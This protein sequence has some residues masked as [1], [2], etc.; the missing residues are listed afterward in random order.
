MT[1]TDILAIYKPMGILVEVLDITID[2][3]GTKW[4]TVKDLEGKH[5]VGGNPYPIKTQYGVVNSQDLESVYICNCFL[6][7]HSCPAC[8]FTAFIA[9]AE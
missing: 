1:T 6:P 2:G 3:E 9:Y 5:F 7:E 4:V 8:E